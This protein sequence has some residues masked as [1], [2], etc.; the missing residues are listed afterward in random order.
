MT[1][2]TTQPIESTLLS[3]I[4]GLGRGVVVT[5]SHFLDLASRQSIDLA[6]HRLVGKGKL[7]RLARGIY[8]YPRR[9]TTLGLLYPS[10]DAVAKAVKGRDAVR[11]QPAGGYAANL[12]G[13]SDQVPLKIVFLTDG[14]TRK[15]ALGKQQILFKR[16]TPRNMATAGKLSGLVIQALRHLGK[17]HVD[18]A[19]VAR[20]LARI[21]PDDRKDLLK[22]ARYA[23]E[24]IA[25]IMRKIAQAK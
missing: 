18:D 22:A 5:P 23:P 24:W 17:R 25:I 8:D 20:L 2:K 13:L 4:Y 15:I 3:R 12:L 16:T 11:I 9:D 6:L 7:R 19:I 21:N 10:V 14:L 1:A